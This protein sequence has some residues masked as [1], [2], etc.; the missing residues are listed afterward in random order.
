MATSSTASGAGAGAEAAEGDAFAEG[1]AAASRLAKLTG[2]PRRRPVPWR[3]FPVDWN[4]FVILPIGSMYG[5]YAN[6]KGVY[7]WDPCYHIYMDPMGYRYYLKISDWNRVI[8]L[9]SGNSWNCGASECKDCLRPSQPW[10]RSPKIRQCHGCE[11]QAVQCT[12]LAPDIFHMYIYILYFL[13]IIY[14]YIYNIYIYILYIYQDIYIKYIDNFGVGAHQK[15]FGRVHGQTQ[16]RN[17]LLELLDE[18]FNNRISWDL[19]P[20]SLHC[21]PVLLPHVSRK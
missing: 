2:L 11:P 12:W 16:T 10:K 6:I 7:W 3:G 17:R 18:H 15:V 9:V 14:I 21:I 4:L 5:I 13:Y 8:D 20:T 1:D 19:S